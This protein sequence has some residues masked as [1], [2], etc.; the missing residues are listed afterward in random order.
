MPS[1]IWLRECHSICILIFER[2]KQTSI[3]SHAVYSYSCMCEWSELCLHSFLSVFSKLVRIHFTHTFF[4]SFC[5]FSPIYVGTCACAYYSRSACRTYNTH[6][7]FETYTESEGEK[8]CGGDRV[9]EL[10]K[11]T[12]NGNLNIKLYKNDDNDE[13]DDNSDKNR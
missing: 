5:L 2:T 7:T 9:Q 4:F 11:V 13:V 10:V 3:K 1:S 8:E 12:M 6:F